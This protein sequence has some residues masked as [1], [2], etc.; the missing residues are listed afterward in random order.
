MYLKGQ[1]VPRDYAV[2]IGWFARVLGGYVL[3][4]ILTATA[5]EV[6]E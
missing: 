5:N 2:A 6:I 1:G 4:L 3:G